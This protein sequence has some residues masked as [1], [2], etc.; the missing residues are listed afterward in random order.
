ME[1][2]EVDRQYTMDQQA[3]VQSPFSGRDGMVL[4]FIVHTRTIQKVG[5]RMHAKSFAITLYR[6]SLCYSATFDTLTHMLRIFVSLGHKLTQEHAV[7]TCFRWP[8]S[9]SLLATDSKV[10][11]AGHLETMS[12]LFVKDNAVLCP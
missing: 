4:A 10:R 7:A 6:Y 9:A 8:V 12:I 11:R 2:V 1:H 3:T 5:V